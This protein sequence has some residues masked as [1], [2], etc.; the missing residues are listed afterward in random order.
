MIVYCLAYRLL[1][2]VSVI[3]FFFNESWQHSF[4]QR[5]RFF[6]NDLTPRKEIKALIHRVLLRVK[7]TTREKRH[8][9]RGLKET[10]D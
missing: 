5:I 6:F 7:V 8:K 10:E 3:F 1:E 4:F 9:I 2:N